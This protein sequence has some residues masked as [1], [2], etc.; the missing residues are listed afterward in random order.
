M[1]T[2]QVLFLC[3]WNFC[4]ILFYEKADNETTAFAVTIM[5]TRIARPVWLVTQCRVFRSLGVSGDRGESA[6]S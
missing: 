6:G 1:L 5:F 4:F 2:S 3:G